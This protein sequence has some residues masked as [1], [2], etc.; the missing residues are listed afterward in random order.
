MC[1]RF[2]LTEISRIRTRFGIVLIG[3]AEISPRFNIAPTDA[4][5]VVLEGPRG[6]DLQVMSWGFRPGW[7]TPKPGVPPPINARAETLLVRPMFRDAIVAQR[8]IIPADG[9]FEWKA[10]P[11][12]RQKQPMFIRLRG[13]DLFGFAGLYATRREALGE[14]VQTCLIITTTPNELVAPIHNRMPAILDPEDEALW[15]DPTVPD[16]GA[17]LSCLRPYPS[18]RMEAF[19]VSHLV[20]SFRNDSPDLVQRLDIQP[21]PP[22]A[23]QSSLPHF[24]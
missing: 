19:Q 14:R 20:G 16:P 3:G 5:P 22:E 11:G 10:V 8:C 23:S 2:T 4:I 12:Q 9:F 6:R 1:G 15:L 24:E 21:P 7:V 13:D 17:A 18:E